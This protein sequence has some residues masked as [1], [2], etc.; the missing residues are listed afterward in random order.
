MLTE[1][2]DEEK[3]EIDELLDALMTEKEKANKLLDFF[4]AL[5][6]AYC[7]IFGARAL[8]ELAIDNG[9]EKSD[10]LNYFIDDEELYERIIEEKKNDSEIL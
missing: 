6:N 10:I 8:M 7:D 4:E 5:A 2:M 3:S 9:F 1:E